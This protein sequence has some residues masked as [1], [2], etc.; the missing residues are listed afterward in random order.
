MVLLIYFF[1]FKNETNLTLR[2]LGVGVMGFSDETHDMM[3]IIDE[4][5]N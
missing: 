4:V 5:G 3:T 1:P 2:R